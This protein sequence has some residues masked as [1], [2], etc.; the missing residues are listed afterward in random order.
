MATLQ[1]IAVIAFWAS[2]AAIASTYAVYP[3]SLLLLGRLRKRPHLRDERTPLVTFIISAYNEARVIGEKI[4]NTLSLEYPREKLEIVVISDASDDGTDEIVASFADRGVRLF[5]QET[6]RGKAAGLTR[7]L[8]QTRGQIVVFSDANSLYQPQALRRLV[9]NFA[10]PLVG[11]VVGCQRY[12]KEDESAVSSAERMYWRYELFLKQCESDLGSVVG[13][14][15]AVYAIRSCLF[16]PLRDDDISDF[17]NPLQIIAQDYRGVF[18]PRAVCYESTAADFAGEFRRKV[19]IVNRSFRGLLRVPEVLNP[20]RVGWF[21]YQVFLHKLVRWFVPA[22]LLVML[23]SNAAI[24]WATESV[25]YKTTLAMQLACYA[26]ALLRFVPGMR[27]LKP[28]WM[29]YYFCLANAAAAVGILTSLA[30][31]RFITWNPERAAAG[32][33]GRE[34]ETGR[35]LAGVVVAGLALAALGV[36]GL[37]LGTAGVFWVSLG[38][39]FY[40]YVGYFA[41]LTVARRLTSTATPAAEAVPTVTLIIPAYNEEAVLEAKLENALSLDYPADKLEIIV[42]NDASDDRTE[43]IA[44]SY[45]DRGVQLVSRTHRQGKAAAM[46]RAIQRASGELLCLCD[47]NVTFRPDALTR[48]TQRLGDLAVGAA[49][50]DVRLASGESNFG[51]GESLYYWIERCLQ[52]AE[53]QVGSL[54]GVDGGMCVVR[55]ELFRPPPPDTIL[56]DFVVSMDVI[57]QGYRVVYEPSAIAHEG[58]TPGARQEWRR[59]VRIAAGAV[60]SLKRRQWPPMNRPVEFWQYVSHKGLRWMSPLL[61][62]LLLL[63]N[64]LL[65]GQTA[66]YAVAL[67]VQTAGYLTAV[68]GAASVRFR[69]TRIGGVLFYFVMSNVAMTVGI[70]KGLFD[71][72]PVTWMRTDRTGVGPPR[73]P[74][75]S[76]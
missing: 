48:L 62:L 35:G 41:L 28:I 1:L 74:A 4:E 61:L 24:V 11:Y 9:S 73:E 39:L 17:V 2:L 30:G 29:A 21:A 32:Q 25:V 14:D 38:V 6:R 58:G 5:R 33:R 44:R 12:V 57:A 66:F 40:V 27:R 59:R 49:T 18:E 13:G 37:L 52:S 8:P 64:I 76:S 45:E 7:F 34:S 46:N 71:L 31:M 55:K 51:H 36:C 54:M 67:C 23:V 53:S 56:D 60:Q 22:F 43:E 68:L 75:A 63:T 47:A 20:F 26:A 50:G 65:A 3:C 19:R 70:V 69:R 16:E 10:D 15:G 72:Q 42:A